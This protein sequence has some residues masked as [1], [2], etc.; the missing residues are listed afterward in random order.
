[1]EGARF[2]SNVTVTVTA[3][4]TKV[5]RWRTFMQKRKMVNCQYSDKEDDKVKSPAGSEACKITKNKKNVNKN[6]KL[7]REN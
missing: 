7:A 5:R 3:Q 1:M 2:Q 4:V 6:Q